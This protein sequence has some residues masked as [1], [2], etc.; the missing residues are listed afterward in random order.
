M[1]KKEIEL[2]SEKYEY[3]RTCA[4]R[5]KYRDELEDPTLYESGQEYLAEVE[6][7]KYEWREHVSNHVGIDPEKYETFNE[8][9]ETVA[10]E[11]KRR[12]D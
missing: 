3:F 9:E 10:K 1:R 6:R 5:A 12:W 7:Q 2:T 11:F 8:Y 4:W